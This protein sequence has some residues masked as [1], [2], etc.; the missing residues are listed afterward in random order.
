MLRPWRRGRKWSCRQLAQCA[1]GKMLSSVVYGA[2]RGEQEA[3]GLKSPLVT[4]VC[5]TEASGG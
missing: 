1:G 2:P 4:A 3:A 5:V